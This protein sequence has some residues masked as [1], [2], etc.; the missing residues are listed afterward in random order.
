MNDNTSKQNDLIEL[1][2]YLEQKYNIKVFLNKSDYSIV[3]DKIEYIYLKLFYLVIFILIIAVTYYIFK[4]YITKYRKKNLFINIIF[5]IL[6]LIISLYIIY[7][8]QDYISLI[9]LYYNKNN[10]DNIYDKSSINYKNINFETGDIL[11]EVVGWNDT[12]RIFSYLL[13]A[14][15]SHCLFNIKF[16]N[17]NYLMHFTASNFGYPDNI[18]SFNS[19]YLEIFLLDDYF[20]DNYHSKKYYRIFKPKPQ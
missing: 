7:L 19:K 20:I 14:E 3:I 18:L 2:D 8:L 16:K 1:K 12:N 15:F 9:F 5:Y 4:K 11:Q 10:N 17:K 13:K 6:L